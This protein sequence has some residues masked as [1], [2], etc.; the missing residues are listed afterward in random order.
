[1]K[2]VCML[3]LTTILILPSRIMLPFQKVMLSDLNAHVLYL[4]CT[5]SESHCEYP[6]YTSNV[7]LGFTRYVHDLTQWCIYTRAYHA[8]GPGPG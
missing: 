6:Y 1:M 4:N 3:S 2:L 8:L 5:L 7:S